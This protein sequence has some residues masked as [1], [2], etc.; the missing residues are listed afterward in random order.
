MAPAGAAVGVAV[1]GAGAWG[2]NHVRVFASLSGA[3]LRWVCDRSERVRAEVSAA[4]PNVQVAPELATALED[5]GVRAVVVASD[6]PT[7]AALAHQVLAAGRDVLVEKPLALTSADAAR[8]CEEAER[9]GRILMVGHLLLYHP[10]VRHLRSALDAGEL[11]E[12]LYLTCQRLNL[13][14]VR[15]EENAWWSLAPHDVSVA[16][17]LLGA[18]PEAVTA[19]G[20]AYLQPE[21]GIEDVVFASLHY[22][23]GRLAHVHVSWLDSHKTRKVEVVGSRGMAVFDAQAGEAVLSYLDRGVE[24]P[25]PAGPGE[26]VRLRSGPVRAQPLPSVEPLVMECEAFLQAVRTGRPP[27]ADGRSGLSVVRVLEAGARSLAAGGQP[28]PVDRGVQ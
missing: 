26:P 4:Y 20:G 9:R 27:L 18:E 2:R 10:A 7:H 3:R 16:N 15:R 21:R 22:P 1:V 8:L 13:G 25:V 12:L 28:V 6:A 19:V 24:L 5:P 11:G 17:H 14:V 23:G